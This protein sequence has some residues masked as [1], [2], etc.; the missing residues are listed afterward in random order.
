M[1]AGDAVGVRPLLSWYLLNIESTYLQKIGS[2]YTLAP[3]LRSTG[4][5]NKPTELRSHKRFFFYI[6]KLLI[7]CRHNSS[8]RNLL[9]PH[10]IT[11]ALFAKSKRR[12]IVLLTK[13]N[14]HNRGLLVMRMPLGRSRNRIDLRDRSRFGPFSNC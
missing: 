10:S 9:A 5:Q 2:G 8:G 3:H 12:T 14:A 1:F 4:S 13:H 11:Y 7:T 6:R